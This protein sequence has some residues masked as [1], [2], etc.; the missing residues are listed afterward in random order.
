MRPATHYISNS[1]VLYISD[2]IDSTVAIELLL[3]IA[4]AI[5]VAKSTIHTYI[6]C[7]FASFVCRIDGVVVPFECLLIVVTLHCTGGMHWAE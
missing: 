3:I 7:L 2:S 5:H 1:T 4:E 6:L